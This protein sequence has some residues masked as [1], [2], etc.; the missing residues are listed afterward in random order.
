ARPGTAGA[1]PAQRHGQAAAGR[2]RQ[3][4]DRQ[5][6]RR[7]IAAQHG[8]GGNAHDGEQG[9]LGEG[10]TG[11]L[12]AGDPARGQ[13]RVLLLPLGGQQPGGQR[14]GRGGQQDQ[15]QRADQQQGPGHHQAAAQGGQGLR[16]AGGRLQL[17][18]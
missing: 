18:Q 11:E 16:Q 6:Q 3:A 7:E 14:R 17:A 12:A 1:A 4:A 13:Q 5:Q 8:P 10:G 9:R 2:V 15:L